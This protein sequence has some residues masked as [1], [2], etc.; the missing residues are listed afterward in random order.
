L[1]LVFKG[2]MSNNVSFTSKTI[3]GFLLFEF[4]S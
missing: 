4:I 2:A 3:T 1:I